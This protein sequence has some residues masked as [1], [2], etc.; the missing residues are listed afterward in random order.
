MKFTV[1]ITP[2]VK[3][4]ALARYGDGSMTEPLVLT[5]KSFLGKI[6]ELSSRKVGFR[7]VLP[8]APKYPRS[9][10][11]EVPTL[12]NRFMPPELC[13]TIGRLLDEFFDEVFF[14]QVEIFLAN[15]RSDYDAVDEFMLNHGI[16]IEHA[17]PG[18]LR[19]RWRDRQ[20]KT[21]EKLERAE[22]ES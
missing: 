10:D 1:P 18:V 14:A 16:S 22:V 15:D 4:F 17:D 19:K 12:R 9:L 7:H 11:I 13:P 6:V 8:K 5:R 2:E 3:Q 21:R 20:R